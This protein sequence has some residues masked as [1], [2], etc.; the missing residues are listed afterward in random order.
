MMI[1]YPDP[2]SCFMVLSISPLPISTHYCTT[3]QRYLYP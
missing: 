3:I 2:L 1:L